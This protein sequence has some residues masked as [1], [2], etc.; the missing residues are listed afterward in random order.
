MPCYVGLSVGMKGDI[1]F[2]RLSKFSNSE[3]IMDIKELNEAFFKEHEI[4]AHTLKL[5]GY[6]LG[7]SKIRCQ[8]S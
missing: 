7:E 6:F 3:L 2:Y 8:K 4:H 5:A 1:S